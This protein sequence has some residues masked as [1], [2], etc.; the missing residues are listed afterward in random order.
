MLNK[1]DVPGIAFMPW[2]LTKRAT[3]G[4]FEEILDSKATAYDVHHASNDT[5]QQEDGIADDG[6][7]HYWY[8]VP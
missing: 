1:T 6:G 8:T 5:K 3:E 7:G 2:P 4:N